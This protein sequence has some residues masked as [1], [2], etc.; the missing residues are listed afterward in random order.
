MLDETSRLRICAGVPWAVAAC[1]WLGLF[2]PDAWAQDE[3]DYWQVLAMDRAALRIRNVALM[4]LGDGPGQDLVYGD[5]FGIVRVVTMTGLD[6]REVWRSRPLEGPV[7]EVRVED[8]DG[9]GAVEVIALTRGGR[10]YVYD[11]RF[12]P[13]W[14]NLR[15][16]YD[17]ILAIDIANMDLDPAY[18]FVILSDQGFIDYIDGAQFNREF[19]STQTFFANQIKVGNVDS[20]ADL[21]IILNTGHVVDAVL[22]DSQWDTEEFGTQIELL[23]IDGDGLEE[24]LGFTPAEPAQYV[25]IFDADERQEKPL[26]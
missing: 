17:E 24:I 25:R 11:D 21:E 1:L 16:D 23:D 5:R 6:V 13:R 3:L 19:R 2:V 9:D 22:A 4:P 12:T 10:L 7:L 18:E 26:R 15:E 8:L 20:D 14:E